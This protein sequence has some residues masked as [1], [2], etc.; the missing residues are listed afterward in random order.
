MNEQPAVERAAY[1]AVDKALRTA[2]LAEVPPALASAVMARVCGQAAAPRFRLSWLD[3]ALTLFAAGLGGL[4]LL[5]WQAVPA[6]VAPRFQLQLLHW[7]Y[8]TPP[9]ALWGS[10]AAAVGLA[11]AALV[12]GGVLVLR[13]RYRS[14]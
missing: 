1:A 9:A 7:S 8:Y 4:L 2:P 13:P 12:V 5:A 14:R 10:V 3:Y 11:L 6:W